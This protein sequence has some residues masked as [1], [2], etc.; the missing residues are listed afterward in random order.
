MGVQTDDRR[1]VEPVFG[2]TRKD[3]KTSLDLTI[4]H[5]DFRVGIF[6]PTLVIG[7]ENNRSNVPLAAYKNRY[8]SLGLTREF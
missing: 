5:R 6:A 8:I 1:G 4:Y 3:R 2:V 7:V